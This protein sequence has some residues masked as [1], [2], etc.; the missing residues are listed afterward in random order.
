MYNSN[1]V[2]FGAIPLNKVFIKKFDRDTGNFIP[3]EA[4]F[5]K[6][7]AKNK[8][9]LKVT[10][11]VAEQW[12]QNLYM[13]KIATAA[14]WMDYV[15][16]DVYALTTQT[17][18]LKKLKSKQILGFAEMRKDQNFPKYQQLYRLQVKP[19]A[20]NVNQQNKKQYQ[21]VGSAILDSL[22]QIY[23]NIS[24]FSINSINVERFYRKN[25][26]I[27]DYRHD[28]RFIWSDSLIERVKMHFSNLYVR[29]K[30]I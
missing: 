12:Q 25:G 20:I 6:L 7:D 9:D 16:I 10:R 2:S 23:S 22:K 30:Q 11:S 24:L 19:E 14:N 18:N 4:S 29:F 13:K 8:N 26:F 15:P 17:K 27:M 21:K 1:C 5:V 3:I 28:G